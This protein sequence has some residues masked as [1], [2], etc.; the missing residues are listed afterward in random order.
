M[1]IE[2][3]LKGKKIL[4]G[5]V[6]ADRHFNPLNGMEKLRKRF[7]SKNIIIK[8]FISFDDVMPYADGCGRCA[9]R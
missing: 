4:F 7:M 9:R 8:D 6:P 3:P 1:K 2:N 5:T